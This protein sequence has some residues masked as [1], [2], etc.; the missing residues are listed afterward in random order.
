MCVCW[1]EISRRARLPVVVLVGV[2]HLCRTSRLVES[3]R[4]RPTLL[5]EI[6]L[7]ASLHGC[8]SNQSNLFALIWVLHLG[9]CESRVGTHTDSLRRL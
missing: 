8:F 4:S 3:G 9:A 5:R 1:D 7:H 2:I 6:T